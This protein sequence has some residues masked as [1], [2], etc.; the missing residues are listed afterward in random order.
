MKFKFST[1]LLSLTL[2]LLFG[3]GCDYDHGVDPIR[4]R[5]TGDIIFVG[6]TP[7]DYVREASVVIVK[8]I[9]PDN[10]LNDLLISDPLTF[11]PHKAPGQDD[12]VHYE[13]IAEPGTYAAAGVLWR[14]RGQAWDIANV[15]SLYLD[16]QKLTF[17]EI[18]IT[19]EQP[20]VAGVDMFADWSLAKRDAM[21]TGNIK[22]TGGW[23]QD[24]DFFVLGLYST[25]PRNESEFVTGFFSGGAAFKLIF[26][27]S[28]VESIPFSIEVNK[29]V[30]SGADLGKYKFIA[31]FW[32]G[33]DSS[34]ADI[35]TIGFYH[36]PNDS[37]VPRS[38]IAPASAV[39]FTADFSKFV[40]L[41][42][43]IKDG[44]DCP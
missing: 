25:I 39:D 40:S 28:P 7:P 33:K 15:L 34:L 32:K 19:P 1:P 44:R 11:D 41:G 20:I 36:C 13:I 35:R 17:K 38:V 21:I 30:G 18:V 16:L 2:L 12:T 24:T 43:I 3:S 29:D 23:R 6:P 8:K 37:L 42:S 10:L 5:I 22:F 14:K 31:L 26:Q 27:S 4:S 9:P